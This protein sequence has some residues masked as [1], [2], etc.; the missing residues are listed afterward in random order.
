MNL[1]KII[2]VLAG[3]LGITMFLYSIYYLYI[4]LHFPK[5]KKDY[6]E[7]SVFNKFAVL[8]A[9]R[10]EEPVIGELV[11]SLLK[12]NYPK[13][14]FDVIVLPNNC[15]DDTKGA[16]ERAGART[17]EP[18]L[19]VKSKGE[20]L[21]QTLEYLMEHEDHDAYI[22]FDAD[23]IVD[24][25]FLHEMNKAKEA[26]YDAAAGFRD[27]KNPYS[28]YMSSSYSLFYLVVNV[29]YNGARSA[30]GMNALITGTGFMVSREKLEELGGWNTVTITE[31]VEMTLQL[32]NMGDSIA[33][34]PKA[35][36]YD[37]Q[38]I[39]M[40]QAWHQRLRW[41]IGS[42]QNYKLMAKKLL[43]TALQKK[44]K[45]AFDM[46]VMLLATYMQIFGFVAAIVGLLASL[47]VGLKF[48]LLYAVG[49]AL[50]L[51]LAQALVSIIVLKF[52]GKP[53][54]PMYKG[55][56]TIWWFTL[57]WIP[58]HIIALFKDNIEWKE[59]EHKSTEELN[60]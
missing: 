10:N 48:F 29:M 23:N 38:P 51:F 33:F 2:L 17:F 13:D 27:S 45:N 14:K 35:I 42:Q 12:Q 39:D 52:L 9:A 46:F 57:T 5:M 15:N 50:V 41:S 53:I 34:V 16:A 56:L 37:E 19:P 20:V 54:A 25:N 43:N 60:Y 44:G 3:I 21:H 22:V 58:L 59:I 32:S 26:G 30:L 6:P 55:I 40:K 47:I 18:P 1:E 31:D 24:E 7:T 28:T 8:I 4:A 36:T 49:G 11:A